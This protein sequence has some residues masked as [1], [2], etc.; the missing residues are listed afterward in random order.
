MNETFKEAKELLAKL[1]AL[2]SVD[3]S[4]LDQNAIELIDEALQN[5]KDEAFDVHAEDSNE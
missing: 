5:A 3:E 1:K 2:Y 4:P